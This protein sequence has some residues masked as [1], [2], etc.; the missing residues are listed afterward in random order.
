[1]QGRR[2]RRLIVLLIAGAIIVGIRKLTKAATQFDQDVQAA[3]DHYLEQTR[4]EIGFS[5]EDIEPWA[6]NQLCD[7][8]AVVYAKHGTPQAPPIAA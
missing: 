7:R 4:N 3:W 6:W 1:M 2:N 8:I 5:Y